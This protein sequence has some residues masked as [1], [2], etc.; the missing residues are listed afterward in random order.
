MIGNDR[1]KL[2]ER[3]IQVFKQLEERNQLLAIQKD[4]IAKKNSKITSSINYAKR[5][6]EAI[7]PEMKEISK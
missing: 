2:N 7:L 3:F 6:Q 1:R 4:D 5:I